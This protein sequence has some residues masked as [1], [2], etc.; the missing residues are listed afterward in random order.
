M[1]NPKV[2]LMIL[3]KPNLHNQLKI[4]SV[5]EVHY[6]GFYF[7][8]VNLWR[9]VILR[10]WQNEEQKILYP[11]PNFPQRLL[12]AKTVWNLGIRKTLTKMIVWYLIGSNLIIKWF[13]NM[14]DVK[15]SMNFVF[16]VPRMSN[17]QSIILCVIMMNLLW[18][19]WK[20]I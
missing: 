10:K 12:Y 16:Q 20:M 2:I 6:N 4:Q 8:F 18:F 17:Q 1:M 9:D 13:L 15:N 7:Y 19:L 5:L 14:N 3:L 11:L